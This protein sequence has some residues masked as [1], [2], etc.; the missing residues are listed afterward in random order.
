M[1]LK[2]STK[3]AVVV[4]SVLALVSITAVARENRSEISIPRAS[5]DPSNT[6]QS[7][8]GHSGLLLQELRDPIQDV[9]RERWD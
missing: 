8:R 3:R 2:D 7:A 9:F 6:E 5:P 4:L 1:E